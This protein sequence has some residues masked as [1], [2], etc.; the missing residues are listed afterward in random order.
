MYFDRAGTARTRRA[1]KGGH[2]K[3]RLMLQVS[4]S[5]LFKVFLTSL[6]LNLNAGKLF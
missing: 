6:T 4:S 2:E 5:K 3:T 1:G